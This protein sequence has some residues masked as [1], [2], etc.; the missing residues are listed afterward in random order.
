[1][2]R[3]A[4]HEPDSVPVDRAE[5]L[6]DDALR[7]L[8]ALKRSSSRWAIFW[9]EIFAWL[10]LPKALR[11]QHFRDWI[12]R[13]DVQ[14]DLKSLTRTAISGAPEDQE[15][16]IRLTD[17]YTIISCGDQSHAKDIMAKVLARLKQSLQGEADDAD[18]AALVQAGVGSIHQ[19][20]D[21]IQGAVS[22]QK[23]QAGEESPPL[24]APLDVGTIER[25][26]GV[27]SQV[28][29]GW[30][31]EIDGKWIERPELERL[32]ALTTGKESKVTVLLGRPGE[33]K[34][35][36]FARLGA[37]LAAENTALLAI[38]AD[39]IPRKV[40][41][42]ADLDDWIGCPIPVMEALRRLAAVRRVVVLIDQ[43]DALAELMDQHSGR[44]S[45]L[46]RLVGAISNTPNL[47]ILMSC[48]EFEFRNDVRLTT[49]KAE[50]IVLSPLTWNQVSPLLATHQPDVAN[51]NEEVREVLRTPQHLAVFLTH[52]AG[53]RQKMPT[54]SSYQSLLEYVIERRLSQGYGSQTV[55][56][57]ERIA[58][59][60]A[61]EEELWLA[62]NRFEP[63]FSKELKNL[64]AAEFLVSSENNLSI[65]FRHQTLFDFL[66]A[67]SFLRQKMSLSKH[68]IVEKQESL[69]IRPIL[70]STLHY[71]RGA[72]RAIYR[73]EFRHLWEHEGLRVHLRYL[74]ISFL[75]QA[76][77]PDDEEANWLLPTLDDPILRPKTLHAVIGSEGWFARIRSRLPSLMTTPVPQAREI[78]G[79]LN[80]AMAYEPDA[81]F[82][83]IKSYWI[84]D[85]R[86]QELVFFVLKDTLS[87]D[88]S[89]VEIAAQFADRA[90]MDCFHILHVADQIRQSTPDLAPEV[91]VRYL[92]AKTRQIDDKAEAALHEYERLLDSNEDWHGIDKLALQAP[93]A[94]VERLWPW[95]AEVSGRLAQERHPFL[96]E[97][98][99]HHG[100]SFLAESGPHRRRPL[101][102]AIEAAFRAF[103]ETE[104]E[105]FLSFVETNKSTEIEVLHHLIALGLEKIAS[106]YS[107]KVLEYLLE[108]PRRFAIGDMYDTHKDSGNLISAVVPALGEDDALCLETAIIG[109]P[110]YR[111]IPPEEDHKLHFERLKWT[112][113]K[114]LRLLRRFPKERLSTN[115]QRHLAE[116]ERALPNTANYD[117]G[118]LEMQVVGSPMSSEQMAKATNDQIINLF[119]DLPD[120]TEW[121]HPKRRFSHQGGSIQASR[122]F[123]DFAKNDPGRALQIIKQF[124]VGAQERPA[125]YALA[126]LG[127]E[128]ILP[129]RLIACIR[130]LEERGFT[131]EEFKISASRCLREIARRAGGLDDSTC[132]LL[133]SWLS[134]WVPEANE[135]N[136][137]R[138]ETSQTADEQ[139]DS[140]LWGLGS[141]E[142]LPGGN[143]P[144]LDALTLGY[145]LRKPESAHDWLAV[146]ERHLL[147]R[148]DPKVWCAMANYLDRIFRA[149]QHRSLSFLERLF[150]QYPTVLETV[151]GVRLI[152]RILGK[153]PDEMF[154]RILACWISGKW[155]PGPLAAGE[156]ATL[157]FCRNPDE[158]EARRQV[159]RFLAGADYDPLVVTMVRVGVAHTLVVAWGEPQLRELVTPLLVRLASIENVDI[160]EALSPVFV[161]TDPLPPDDFTRRLLEAFLKRPSIL[162]VGS[163]YFVIERLKGLLREGWNPILVQTV[164]NT[165][166]GNSMKDTHA[167]RPG[168]WAGLVEIALTLH[169]LPETRMAGLD[170]F[171][172]LMGLDVYEVP[173]RLKAL[174]RRFP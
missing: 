115:G 101:I 92:Q 29:L 51:W 106:S 107:S 67:R 48:R 154:N 152:E 122:E 43:L 171:E 110:R 88:A 8:G 50:S 165:L 79:L 30:P 95:L 140:I 128:A 31:Q 131:S 11:T 120:D 158:S 40:E 35:A 99:G 96:N 61:Q 141:I 119:E 5:L 72:D 37:Q 94:F 169:R 91:I 10:S 134:R 80:R 60:M 133:E 159:E 12:S 32:Y 53:G 2:E 124:G 121:Q 127:E 69:F 130:E 75:G 46:F 58:S 15:A 138:V 148:E 9:F 153:F 168:D 17:I 98:R 74:L 18:L 21:S 63:E 38:K 163:G 3:R 126:A 65:A 170:L 81:I 149:D 55:E 93:R 142:R 147:R 132:C 113:E 20:L 172:R 136:T 166:V 156:S 104:P 89:S 103:A 66:R 139:Y 59:E 45:A 70:W 160:A 162:N 42:L 25:A 78:V 76:A 1:M 14:S 102:H 157:K 41:T 56:T 22:L 77:E 108:D 146:L 137:R 54:F 109:W 7:R 44:L 82:D 125:G 6:L 34:S 71:L 129:E 164:A 118:S 16:R 27:V 143:Y 57:A 62:R 36:I 39:Q 68:V 111:V 13:Q 4:G 47:H 90:S 123:A 86:Y 64:K 85:E 49:L 150:N 24:P 87:W 114:R 174:D 155:S 161:K 73:K 117:V 173:E 84:E 144:V 28:L 19:R 100:L 105:A 116:E 145:L 135:Q 97:Y 83:L 23:T 167:A 151:A 52:L 33:G 26:F 112:R